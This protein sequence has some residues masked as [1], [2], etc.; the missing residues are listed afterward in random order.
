MP[1]LDVN[2]RVNRYFSSLLYLNEPGLRRYEHST[3]ASG[4]VNEIFTGAPTLVSAPLVSVLSA[5]G[6][7]DKSVDAHLSPHLHNPHNCRLTESSL[8]MF[9]WVDSDLCGILLSF[10]SFLFLLP[11]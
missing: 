11:I 4:C 8:Y 6:E 1:I 2:L 7:P 10:S 5:G 3:V 9:Q